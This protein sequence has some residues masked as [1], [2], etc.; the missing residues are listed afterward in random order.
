MRS[1]SGD[2][3]TCP[4]LDDVYI[5]GLPVE[6]QFTSLRLPVGKL[7]VNRSTSTWFVLLSDNSNGILAVRKLTKLNESSNLQR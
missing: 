2:K 7:G 6:N 1:T 5:G 4:P 3:S